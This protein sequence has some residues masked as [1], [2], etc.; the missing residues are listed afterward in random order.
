M[1]SR[2]ALFRIAAF[3]LMLA[4]VMAAFATSNGAWRSNVPQRDRE[5]V[6]QPLRHQI[7]QPGQALPLLAQAQIAA[8]RLALIAAGLL[9]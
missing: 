4:G 3:L 8:N 1:R 6:A 9:P 5:R 7:G 2:L